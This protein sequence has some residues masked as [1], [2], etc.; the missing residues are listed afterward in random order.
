MTGNGKKGRTKEERKY[1]LLRNIVILCAAGV[2]YYLF[3]SLTGRG[4]PCLFRVLTGYLCPGCGMTHAAAALIHG[5]F[6]GAY[7]ENALVFTV[8]PVLLLYLLYR[9]V[10]YVRYGNVKFKTWE[11]ILQAVLICICIG[12]A[13]WRNVH[14]AGAPERGMIVR[15]AGFLAQIFH[16]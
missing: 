1:R 2:V 12:Y 8:I 6:A 3:F 9:A 14:G 5:D 13:I 11:V 15:A 16:R 10:L 4:I 7:R